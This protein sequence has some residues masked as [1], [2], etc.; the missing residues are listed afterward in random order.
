MVTTAQLQ[1]ASN[2]ALQLAETL[3]QMRQVIAFAISATVA[4][5]PLPSA[6]ITALQNQYSTLKTQLQ[7]LLGQL[8]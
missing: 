6:T 3:E 1:V 4:G 5:V 2:I 8:P 7:A